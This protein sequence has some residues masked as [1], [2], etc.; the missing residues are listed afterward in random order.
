MDRGS[1][2]LRG[3]RMQPPQMFYKARRKI[4]EHTGQPGVGL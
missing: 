2:W 4:R 1:R 3:E